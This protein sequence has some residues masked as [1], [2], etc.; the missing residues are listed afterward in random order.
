MTKLYL[1]I[2]LLFLISLS[3]FAQEP[4]ITTWAPAGG[5][6]TIP[7]TG[8]SNFYD[9]E[10]LDANGNTLQTATNQS[11]SFVS[12]S[13]DASYA[14]VTVKITANTLRIWFN[15]SGDKN[16]IRSIEQWG[17]AQ[18]VSMGRAFYGCKYLICNATDVANVSNVSD[19]SY[20][21]CNASLF[22]GD[23][24]QW[25]VTK[26]TT[27]S[28]MFSGASSF[29]SNLNQ[30][31]VSNV[32]YPEFMFWGASSFNGD[33][34][35][36]NTKKFTK[37]QGMFG[38][39][40]SFNGDLSQWDI[41]SVKYSMGA[42][43]LQMLDYTAMSTENYDNFLMNM[44]DQVQNGSSSVNIV[45]SADGLTYCKA[46]DAKE[47]LKAAGWLIADGG[48]NAPEHLSINDTRITSC[49][50]T[51]LDISKIINP[52][53]LTASGMASIAENSYHVVGQSDAIANASAFS[54]SDYDN[55]SHIKIGFEVSEEHCA[56]QVN[57]KSYLHVLVYDD[58]QLNDKTID[59]CADT[60]PLINLYELM[61]YYGDGTWEFKEGT[62][63]GSAGNNDISSLPLDA[64][65]NSGDYMLD[66]RDLAGH[67]STPGS[68]QLV[69]E[70]TPSDDEC[71]SNAATDEISLTIN[72][73]VIDYTI[74]FDTDGG[75]SVDDI[76]YNLL[77]NDV[78]LSSVTST[79]DNHIFKGWQMPDGSTVSSI[80]SDTQSNITLTATWQLQEDYT[81]TFD[82]N[83]GSEVAS[84][85]YTGQDEDIDLETRAVTTWYGYDFK[86]WQNPDGNIVR[87]FPVS[88]KKDITLTAQWEEATDGTITDD[89][90]NTYKT[91]KIGDQ[92][93]MAENLR[94]TKYN[95]GSSIPLIT[96][97]S[98]WGNRTTPAYCWYNN[99]R[100]T[101]VANNYGALYN[102][103]TVNTGK[104]CPDGWH[105]PTDAEWQT[106][107][108]HLRM[109]GSDANSTDWRGT[110]Q[111]SQLAGT[112]SLWDS[113]SLTTNSGFGSSGFNAL[114]SG[115]RRLYYNFNYEG[116]HCDWWSSTQGSSSRAYRRSLY[117]LNT[118]IYRSI[119]YK[120]NGYSVRCVKD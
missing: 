59:V 77:S 56:Q 34:S 25:N 14:T 5:T 79:K 113:G 65:N 96:D 27:L 18:W 1:S 55:D 53:T 4:F 99:D 101:A 49:S 116:S 2:T 92:W 15:N 109:S 64:F 91:I 36:W 100:S 47:Q 98:S 119:N 95:D 76:T 66:I 41:S 46:K 48:T 13:I 108:M 9:I 26:A 19:F 42:A 20:A 104:L 51:T 107:E 68:L 54:L 80:G 29:N 67:V 52:E 10:I 71:L 85:T 110:N 105:V 94:T 31:D 69:F 114:P 115:N 84:I 63:A 120:L 103:H 60:Y 22:N 82:A 89:D 7:L 38:Y 72:W 86:G 75:S 17:D 35:S 11:R 28:Y 21:F 16:K 61:G 50:S 39:A 106:L 97:N 32:M 118:G 58:Y 88:E 90:G 111:G 102:W 73:D 70:Y 62:D 44:N 81:I 24:S 83:G 43:M 93:W 74:S 87:V 8:S 30:W 40:S 6:I 112:A 12:N 78:D 57:D 33:V 117:Y 37:M 45:L 23:L 3:A